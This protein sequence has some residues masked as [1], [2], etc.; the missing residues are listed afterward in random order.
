MYDWIKATGARR[1]D[2]AHPTRANLRHSWLPVTNKVIELR[3][4]CNHPLMVYP[5]E[6]RFMGDGVVTSCGK[7]FWLDRLLV[8]LFHTG[9]RVLLFSTMTRLLDLVESYLR[10]R[11]VTRLGEKEP[12]YMR[13]LRIDGNTVLDDREAHIAEFNRPNSG[14]LGV[15]WLVGLFRV[16]VCVCVG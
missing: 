12:V 9:H 13:Y 1:E 4:V 14:A 8:K 5:E 3:K 7:M 15:G 2:P 10:W 11:K 6:E 16:C